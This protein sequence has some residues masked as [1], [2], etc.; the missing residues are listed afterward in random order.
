MVIPNAYLAKWFH[1]T[2]RKM[3]YPCLSAV[4]HGDES[5]NNSRLVVESD[6]IRLAGACLLS[7]GVSSLM[8]LIPLLRC[9]HFGEKQDAGD[10]EYLGDFFFL[11]TMFFLQ[12][13]NENLSN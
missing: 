13:A 10:R 5:P 12:G 8:L 7:I 4:E 1:S 11:R 9:C 6:A 3:L 2:P